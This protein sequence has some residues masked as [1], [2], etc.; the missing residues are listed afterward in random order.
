M[1]GWPR[2]HISIEPRAQLLRNPRRHGVT[3]LSCCW[4]RLWRRQSR[5]LTKSLSWPRTRIIIESRVTCA[6][7]R[8]CGKE[9]MWIARVGYE[10]MWRHGVA[11]RCRRD[12]GWRL[13]LP[14]CCLWQVLSASHDAAGSATVEVRPTLAGK[15]RHVLP[16]RRSAPPRAPRPGLPTRGRPSRGRRGLPTRGGGP[17]R[18]R[19]GW[20]PRAARPACS[21]L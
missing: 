8:A 9:S 10:G 7:G 11:Q 2:T 19:R 1:R 15:N 16:P 12:R 5:R 13:L 3:R 20:L 17:S 18:G 6:E 21:P 4:P 14:F